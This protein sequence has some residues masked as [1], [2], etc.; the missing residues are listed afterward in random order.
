MAKTKEDI[1][2]VRAAADRLGEL[3]VPPK[4]TD[5]I[6]RWANDEEDRIRNEAREKS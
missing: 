1:K 2:S 6:R 4:I 5:K 3:G